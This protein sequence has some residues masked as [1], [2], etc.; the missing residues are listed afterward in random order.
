VLVLAVAV[1]LAVV[2]G[3]VAL[4]GAAGL[5][6]RVAVAVAVVAVLGLGVVATFGLAIGR[7]GGDDDADRPAVKAAEPDEKA[8]T[9]DP[10]APQ[11][12]AIDA[13]LPGFSDDDELARPAPVLD[14]LPDTAIRFV[15][16]GT[17][18][19]AILQQCALD[20]RDQPTACGPATPAG[21]WDDA[22]VALVELHRELTTADGRVVDCASARCVLVAREPEGGKL[23]T[24]SVLV[25]GRP[26]PQAE[27]TVSGGRDRRPGERV[28]ARLAGFDPRTR[29]TVTWCAPPGPIDP[30][31]CGTPAASTVVTTDSG[32]EATVE[33]LVPD[34]VG[35]RQAPC[36]PRATCAV[37]VRGAAVPV[38][39]VPVGFAGAAGPDLPAGRVLGGL[40]V[41]A[42]AGALAMWL[43]RSRQPGEP[44]P[45]EGVS[46]AV[47][48]WDDIDLRVET[49]AEAALTAA[50]GIRGT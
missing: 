9:P 19:P 10:A 12:R 11:L 34:E 6:R 15:E 14:E 32:G 29:V 37:A 3:G 17:S 28:T 47:P 50:P 5:D 49:D 16:L 36:G 45:F 4:A 35:E 40:A 39:P 7:G 41:L 48:E 22:Q 20:A 21:Y 8:T 30:T 26:A 43:L 2:A 46:L 33:L 23:V 13:V 31:A 27:L 1:L 38:A 18:V 25:F 24:G 44:D 42:L